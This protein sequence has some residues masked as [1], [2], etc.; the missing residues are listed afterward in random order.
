MPVPFFGILIAL[1]VLILMTSNIKTLTDDSFDLIQKE[2]RLPIII[3]FETSWCGTCHLMSH[4][5][6]KLAIEFENQVHFFSMDL[7]SNKVVPSRFQILEIPSLV[8]INDGQVIQKIEGMIS[9][10]DLEKKITALV[11]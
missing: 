1:L 11:R 7:E 3:L 5:L 4:M 10:K 9:R 6:D 8:V 2:T